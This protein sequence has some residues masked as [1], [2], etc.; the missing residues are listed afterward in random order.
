MISQNG[1]C[2][3]LNGW[4]YHED[5]GFYVDG[6]DLDDCLHQLREWGKRS[7]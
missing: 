2:R 6:K 1:P 3:R 7:S 4:S 5:K